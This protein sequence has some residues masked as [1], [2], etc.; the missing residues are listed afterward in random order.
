[1][2]I[3]EGISHQYRRDST[4]LTDVGL[5]LNTGILGLLGP[6]GA[7]KS[8]LMRIVATL[9]SPTRGRVVLDGYEAPKAA[10]DIRLQLGYLPQNFD[11]YPRATALEM[12]DH[13]ATLKRLPGGQGRRETLERA[14]D[15]VNLGSVA[16]KQLRTFSGGMMQRFGIAQALLGSPRLIVVDEPTA[17][18]DPDERHVVLNLLSE[19]SEQSII[20]LSTHLVEDVQES[21]S[22]LAVLAD[23][24]IVLSGAVD[25]LLSSKAGRVWTREI[26]RKDLARCEETHRLLS[27]R[28]NGGRLTVRVESPDRPEPGFEAAR[29]L[30]EDVYF[31]VLRAG[32]RRACA[33]V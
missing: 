32:S 19:R 7:G 14:L 18:L 10:H 31:S 8:T 6:N 1:M 22:Q 29:P 24:H 33:S 16:R 23:G 9:L 20:L 27:R 5:E 4:A 15:E 26:D 25:S 30:I 13:I 3:L 11:A 21:C 12:L 28:L 2:L 17:G